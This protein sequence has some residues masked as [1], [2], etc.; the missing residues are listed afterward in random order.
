MKYC[1]LLTACVNPNGMSR[2]IHQDTST[3]LY[4]YLNAIKF[5]YNST[6]LPIVICENSMCDLSKYFPMMDR[7]RLEFLTFNGNNYDKNIGKSLGEANIIEYALK[8]STLVKKSKFLLKI[9]G[10]LQFLNIRQFIYNHK[11]ISQKNICLM[12]IV[13][14]EAFC[15]SRIFIINK[16]YLNQFIKLKHYI[17]EQISLDFE[18]VF[19]HYINSNINNC[20]IQ[21]PLIEPI[22][23]QICGTTGNPY[24]QGRNDSLTKIKYFISQL[25]YNIKL[26]IGYIKNRNRLNKFA[27]FKKILE[28]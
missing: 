12:N 24:P 3:R 6:N 16:E 1:I 18:R 7:N 19:M 27:N 10:R 15:D 20:Y 14:T 17:N 13:P 22:C 26:T 4:E 28:I 11:L 23:N 5:Y 21:V 25:I 9:T 2:T 8:N